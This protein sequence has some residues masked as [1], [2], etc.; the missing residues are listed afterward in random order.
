M[1][2][3][4]LK[5]IK[6]H[7]AKDQAEAK[8]GIE[9]DDELKEKMENSK[10]RKLV[11]KEGGKKEKDEEEEEEEEEDEKE[12]GKGGGGNWI[13]GAIKRP[14]QLHRDLGV[15]QGQKIPPAKLAAAKRSSNPKIRQRANLAATLKKMH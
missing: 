3:P 7:L 11:Q 6:K 5:T 13:K 10:I 8:K 2:L 12:D 15:P 1:A 9:E 14:G 4:I